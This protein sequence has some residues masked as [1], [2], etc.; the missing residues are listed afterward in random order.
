M[1]FSRYARLRMFPSIWRYFQGLPVELSM[2]NETWAGDFYRDAKSKKWPELFLYS[3]SDAYLPYQY[4]E[5][6]PILPTFSFD[7]N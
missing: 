1:L 2:M 7:C 4:L 6:V 3:K 5:Q